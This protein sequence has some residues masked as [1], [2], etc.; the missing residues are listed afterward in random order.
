MDMAGLGTLINAA[1]I[2]AG[3]IMGLVFGKFM[4]ER[5]QD[6]LTMACGL[7]VIFI[8]IAGTMEKM[9]VITRDGLT[10]QGT[11]MVIGSFTLGSLAG[12]W[13]NIEYYLEQFG[14]WLKARTKSGDS[15]FVEA[16]VT[17]S[18]TVCIG[19]MAVV[20]AIRDGIYGDYSIL[21]AKA[22][23]DLII[24]MV[25]TASMGKGCVFSAIPVA[26]FQGSVTLLARLVEPIMT[27]SALD[28]LSLTGSMLIFCVGVNLIWGKKVKVANMLPTLLIAVAWSAV[29]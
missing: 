16:F 29:T 8:G 7:S 27:Q 17:A 22:V 11:M 6:T 24:I 18:L 4:K 15:R 14:T 25:M 23:L 20:G 1:G 19:A 5:Y 13:L 28:N 26:L 2:A 9:M 12:E 21:T 3:G 10:T